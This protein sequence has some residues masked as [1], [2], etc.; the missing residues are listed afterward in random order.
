M[1]KNLNLALWLSTIPLV[2]T[3]NFAKENPSIIERFYSGLIYPWFFKIHQFFFQLF[4]FSYGDVFYLIFT[5]FIINQI[6]KKRQYWFIKPWSFFNDFGASMILVLWIFYLS[7]G[8]NYHRESLSNQLGISTNY[9]KKDLVEVTK[10]L[11]VNVNQLHKEL[12]KFDSIAV[13]PTNSK[14]FFLKSTTVYHPTNRIFKIKSSN[15]KQSMYSLPISYMGY[16]GYLNPFTLESQVNSKIP[17]LN[18]ITTFLHETAHQMGYAS[19][20]EANFIAYYSAIKNDDPYVRYAGFSFA[21]RYFLSELYIIDKTIASQLVEEINFGVLLNFK[22]TTDFWKKYDN[23][24][25]IIFDKT[26]DI[27]LKANGELSGLKSYNEIVGLVINYHKSIEE[28]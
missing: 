21:L 9:N 20:K 11:I 1:I 16:A 5:I 2:F 6:I 24:F 3:I 25:E 19:E 7:W 4:P 10:K 13:S 23:P 27:Y 26:Y 28:I 14:S 17:T 15:V 18:L 8:F 12:V 22:E